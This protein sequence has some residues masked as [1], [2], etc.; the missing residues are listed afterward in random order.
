MAFDAGRL[1]LVTVLAA[2]IHGS[3]AASTSAGCTAVMQR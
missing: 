2:A 1:E 3:N